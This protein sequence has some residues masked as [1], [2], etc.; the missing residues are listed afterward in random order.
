MTFPIR[1]NVCLDCEVNFNHAIGTTKKGRVTIMGRKK[2]WLRTARGSGHYP[3]TFNFIYSV[4]GKLVQCSYCGQFIP[5]REITR[6]HVYPKSKG[7]I[8]KTP[9]CEPCNIEKEDMLPIAWAI[10]MFKV[11]RD[12]AIIPIGY[13]M[14]QEDEENAA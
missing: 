9:S 11:G 14:Q 2:D 4:N 12:I 8:I 5:E 3:L 6:D 1:G 13:T 7:G 10:H